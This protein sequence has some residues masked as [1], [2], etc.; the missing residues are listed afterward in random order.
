MVLVAQPCRDSIPSHWNFSRFV[1]QVVKHR[2]LVEAMAQRLGDELLEALPDFGERLGYDGKA[3]RSHS[4]GRVCRATGAASD[5]DADWGR[6]ET[7]GV[8]AKTGTAWTKVKSWFGYGLHLIADTRYEVPVAYRVTSASCSEVKQLEAM[9]DEVF[10]RSPGLAERC[11]D[12][13]ADRGLDSG[14]LK[15]KLWQSYQ[16]RPLIEPRSH[17]R[18]GRL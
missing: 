12:F 16:V 11:R 3:I 7:H 14:A 13:S 1:R 4:T 15:A 9:V 8:D 2:G 6:H 10:E 5:R 18:K 17:P